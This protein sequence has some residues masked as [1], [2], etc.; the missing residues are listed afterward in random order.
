MSAAAPVL[1]CSLL[2]AADAAAPPSPSS[3][4]RACAGWSAADVEVRGSITASLAPAAGADGPE[5]A[6]HFARIFMWDLDLRKDVVAGDRILVLWRRDPAG[7]LEV[8]AARYESQRLGRELRA[9]RF[10]APGDPTPSYWDPAGV[11][12]PRRLEASPLRRYEQITALL[13]DRPTHQGMDFKTPTGT[14][15]HAP[16][17]GVVTRVDWKLRGNGHC[18]E[19][20]YDDGTMAKFLHLSSTKV[21]PGAR[22]AAGQVIALT[23]NT[24][25]STAPHLHYQLNRGQRTVDPVDY[26]GASR[27]RLAQ[28]DVEAL[29]KEIA[30][31][32]RSCGRL[33]P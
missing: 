2:L 15:V 33:A 28:A 32:A 29:R 27:R 19:V 16:R 24:G 12:V 9:Y 18:L 20:R 8:G 14:P 4:P 7:Q 6:A 5:V 31:F 3:A 22:V 21:R 30:G 13:K 26:H 10:R 23:G 1:A 17:P 25:R 11:E